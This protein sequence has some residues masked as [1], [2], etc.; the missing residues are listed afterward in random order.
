[1]CYT[2]IKEELDTLSIYGSRRYRHLI[3]TRNTHCF[4]VTGPEFQKYFSDADKTASFLSD[5]TLIASLPVN[6]CVPIH[7]LEVGCYPD[8]TWFV[9]SHLSCEHHIC[10]SP[11]DAALEF[12][13]MSTSDWLNAGYWKED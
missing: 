4:L 12:S 2:E 11:E 5:F 7:W 10:F 13:A 3:V 8:N 9:H 1:M 6:G